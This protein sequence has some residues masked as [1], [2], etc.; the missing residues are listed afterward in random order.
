MARINNGDGYLFCS[1]DIDNNLMDVFESSD[2]CFEAYRNDIIEDAKLNNYN[3]NEIEKILSFY[4]IM[5]S[6]WNGNWAGEEDRTKVRCNWC[7]WEGTDNDLVTC[8]NLSDK[9]IGHD[10]DYFKGCPNCRVDDYLMDI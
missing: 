8:V 2:E 9:E 7:D 4:K 6:N 5:I 10:I 3:E 1:I